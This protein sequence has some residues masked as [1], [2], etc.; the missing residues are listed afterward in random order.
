M[1]WE[2]RAAGSAACRMSLE[3]VPTKQRPRVDT[4]SRRAY[5]PKPTREAEGR[6]RAAWLS[7]VGSRWAGWTG[8]VRVE[9][10]V[11]RPLAKGRPRRLAGSPDLSAPDAD[12]VAKAVCDALN[13]L[14]YADDRQVTR[15]VVAF[16]PRPHGGGEVSVGVR[17]DYFEAVEH[18]ERK[19]DGGNRD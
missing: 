13:G 1:S 17:V 4:R 11:R 12:N 2:S 6:I 18:V 16:L 5:T 9:I 10:E 14:A 8:E 3:R 15:L 19:P 7:Q